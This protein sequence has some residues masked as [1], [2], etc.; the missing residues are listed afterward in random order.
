[1]LRP[2]PNFSTFSGGWPPLACSAVQNGPGATT[3]ARMPFS[4]SCLDNA[5]V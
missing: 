1:M 5:L 4:S 3:L 2:A